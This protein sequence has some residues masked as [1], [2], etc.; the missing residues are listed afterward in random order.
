MVASDGLIKA[1]EFKAKCLELMDRVAQRGDVFVITKRG[2][3]LADDVEITGD[4]IEHIRATGGPRGDTSRGP[5][6]KGR[7]TCPIPGR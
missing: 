3:F 7:T 4:V 2:K 1:G 6:A 5:S